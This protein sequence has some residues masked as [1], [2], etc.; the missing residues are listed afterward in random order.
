MRRECGEAETVLAVAVSLG[1]LAL[2]LVWL[3]LLLG[4][5]R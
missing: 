1:M 2:G 5:P 3:G 4:G